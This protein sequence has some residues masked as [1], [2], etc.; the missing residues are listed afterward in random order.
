M[1]K[2]KIFFFFEI[3]EKSADF[4]TKFG[5]G[6]SA[7]K[8]SP[9]WKKNEIDQKRYP[10][11]SVFFGFHFVFFGFSGTRGNFPLRKKKK[12]NGPN[13]TDAAR[14]GQIWGP[15]SQIW[16]VFQMWRSCFQIWP[17]LARSGNLGNFFFQKKKKNPRS[18]QIW[19]DL[20]RSGNLGNFF[21]QK[22]KKNPRSGQIW[23]DL[24]R[25]G[26]IWKSGHFFF[27]LRF[28]AIVSQG[29]GLSNFFFSPLYRANFDDL[30]PLK[31]KFDTFEHLWGSKTWFRAPEI[32]WFLPKT[33]RFLKNLEKK[34]FFPGK[35]LT[36]E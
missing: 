32:S 23:P 6:I 35:I 18:G 29:K 1:K 11:I 28:L 8:G 24:A 5:W 10:N 15:I 9:L 14:S 33:S 19:P 26:Q 31:A 7:T 16:L 20:A 4:A 34:F 12:R 30:R 21:F 22:K 17:D 25:S 36:P 13:Y 3:F 27:F 2:K